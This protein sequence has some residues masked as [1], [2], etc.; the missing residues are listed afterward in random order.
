M[1][2]RLRK[3]AAAQPAGVC[4]NAAKCLAFCIFRPESSTSAGV[5]LA[6]A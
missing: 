6:E 3:S 2:R 4:Q 1:G 5:I